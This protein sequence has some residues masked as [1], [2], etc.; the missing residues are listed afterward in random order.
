MSPENRIEFTK[1]DIDIYLKEVAKEYRKQVGKN[2]PAELI[3]V[4]GASVLI[5]YEFRNMTID[6]DALIRAGDSMKD[7]INSVGER[8]H[9]P[10]GWLNMDFTSTSSY[11]P[12]LVQFSEYY[13]TFSNVMTVRTVSAEYLIAMKLRSGRLY[14]NDLSDVLG[15]LAEHEKREDPITMER[16]ETAVR[17]LY[18]DWASLPENSRQFIKNAMGNGNFAELY[19]EV[20]ESERETKS[21]LIEFVGKYPKAANESNINEVIASLKRRKR[22]KEKER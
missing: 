7:A 11:T 14:K 16:I 13:R 9:L 10:N 1:T 18:G 17:N 6:I 8:F 5:N 4:G 19:A 15:I 21:E 2:V 12:E 3:L 22:A 20:M